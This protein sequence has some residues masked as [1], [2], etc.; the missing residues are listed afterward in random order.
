MRSSRHVSAAVLAFLLCSS[1]ALTANPKAAALVKEGDR[2]YR[3]N[4]YREAAEALLKAKELEPAAVLLYNIARA[5]DQAG[6]LVLALDNYRQFVGQE[7]A[8]PA[9]VKKANLAMDR[10]RTLVAKEEAGKQL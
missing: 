5:F 10:L 8:D 1:P 2:L 6:E 4:K 3:E 9:L 7:S